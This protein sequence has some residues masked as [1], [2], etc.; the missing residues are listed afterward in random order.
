MATNS[1]L[2]SALRDES[3]S[4]SSWIW[5]RS[6]TVLTNWYGKSDTAPVSSPVFKRTGSFHFLLGISCHAVRKPGQPHGETPVEENWSPGLTVPSWKPRTVCQ[7]CE[8]AI[9]EVDSPVSEV[10]QPMSYG[11]E[12]S[13]RTKPCLNCKIWANKWLFEA[14]KF[15]SGLLCS[16]REATQ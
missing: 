2:L 5:V 14:T 8:W 3:V 7:A 13:C 10:L 15:W 6:L 11:T 4:P 16:N 9:L 1:L 12:T